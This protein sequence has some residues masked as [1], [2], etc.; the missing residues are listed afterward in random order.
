MKNIHQNVVLDEYSCGTG[1]LDIDNVKY[2]TILRD[3]TN[4]K[5]KYVCLIERYNTF[6]IEEDD[7]DS[8]IGTYLFRCICNENNCNSI[9]KAKSIKTKLKIQ[10]FE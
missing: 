5:V 1:E 3:Y 6:Y 9:A 2:E 7:E 4:Y 8:T 10:S